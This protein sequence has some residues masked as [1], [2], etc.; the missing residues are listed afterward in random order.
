MSRR[1]RS[2]A[3]PRLVVEVVELDDFFAATA[4]TGGSGVAGFQR[5]A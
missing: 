3:E 1:R 2:I 4:G 5:V